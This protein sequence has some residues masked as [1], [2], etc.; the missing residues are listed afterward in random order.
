MVKKYKKRLKGKRIIL[1]K[2]EPTI[3]NAQKTFALVDRSRS[4]FRKWLPW[5]DGTLKAED[6]L[7]FLFDFEE[8]FEEGKKLGY[9]IYIKNELV[10][11]IDIIKIDSKTK[12]GEV[13]Y[14]I[15]EKAG[16]KG[17]MTEA[18]KMIEAEAFGKLGFN[19][20]QI[21]TDTKNK[22]SIRVAEKCGYKLE[23]VLRQDSFSNYFNELRDTNLFSKLKSEF[24]S[25]DL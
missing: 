15:S 4:L 2:I 8:S 22:A 16:G 5:V 21:Q 18:L 11:R 9:G 3:E 7:K 19:R 12:S 10:G 25:N 24:L 14:W 20:I 1:K 17:Y 13:G 6:S 23:G